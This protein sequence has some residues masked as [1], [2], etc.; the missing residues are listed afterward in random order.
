MDT[1][2]F[3]HN[4]VVFDTSP[5]PKNARLKIFNVS[6]SDDGIYRCRVDFKASQTR[7]SRL[8]LTVVGKLQNLFYGFGGLGDLFFKKTATIFCPKFDALAFQQKISFHK[9][10]RLPLFSPS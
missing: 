10:G 7:T 5:G 2:I 3:G 1:N 4:R 8:N 9:L 6:E